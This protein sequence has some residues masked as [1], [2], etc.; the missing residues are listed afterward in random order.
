M[1][2]GWRLLPKVHT[3]LFRGTESEIS[4]DAINVC[5]IARRDSSDSFRPLHPFGQ[6]REIR[7]PIRCLHLRPTS[8]RELGWGIVEK[9]EPRGKFPWPPKAAMLSSQTSVSGR[10]VYGACLGSVRSYMRGNAAWGRKNR[11]I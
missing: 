6:F 7:L 1:Q 10:F 4:L 8:T 5:A 3:L 9:A 2:I 11:H